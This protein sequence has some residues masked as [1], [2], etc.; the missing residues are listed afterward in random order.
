MKYVSGAGREVETQRDHKWKNLKGIK[1]CQK[2]NI[3]NITFLFSTS[4]SLYCSFPLL[5]FQLTL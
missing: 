4:S 1:S 2:S 3:L 5:C